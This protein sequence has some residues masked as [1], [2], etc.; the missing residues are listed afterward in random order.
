[1][2]RRLW[3]HLKEFN[4]SSCMIL[5]KFLNLSVPKFPHLEILASGPQKML[6]KSSL[7]SF[8]HSLSPYSSSF[9]Y[10]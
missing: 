7:S 2:S 1:M 3:E 4:P 8:P 10:D 6:C 5:A 9:S